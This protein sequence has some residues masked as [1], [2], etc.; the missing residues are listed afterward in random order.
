MNASVKIID[1]AQKNKLTQANAVTDYGDGSQLEFPRGIRPGEF[2]SAAEALLEQGES[3]YCDA[4]ANAQR[5]VR[6]QIKYTLTALGFDLTGMRIKAQIS[7]LD[8]LGLLAPRLLRKISGPR[9]LM[10]HAY[11]RPTREET[12]DAL[13]IASLF[14]EATN[15]V[16]SLY[17]SYS[18]EATGRRKRQPSLFF[19][20]DQQAKLFRVFM[21]MPGA[22]TEEVLIDQT[23]PL[24]VFAHRIAIAFSREVEWQSNPKVADAMFEFLRVAGVP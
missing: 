22:P 1:F 13:D 15:R 21:R 17:W 7:L 10:E 5:A 24:F 12:E 4:V 18:I 9:N 23:S 6:A 2:I 19:S 8:S 16:V 14:V 20:F 3:G 11:K